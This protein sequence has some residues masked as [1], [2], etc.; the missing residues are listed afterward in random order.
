[1]PCLRAMA[2]A[3]AP[4]FVLG[5]AEQ[6]VAR[7][8]TSSEY[9]VPRAHRAQ[10]SARSLAKR[11]INQGQ[12]ALH[13]DVAEDRIARAD[14][15]APC[16]RAGFDQT[17]NAF[18]EI[19]WF[20]VR[21]HVHI[22]AAEG[23]DAIAVPGLELRCWEDRILEGVLAVNA[24]VLDEIRH[25]RLDVPTGVQKVRHTSPVGQLSEATVSWQ[26]VRT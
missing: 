26:D 11:L 23:G 18:S 3:G 21:E 7:P 2:G 20:G 13:R 10:G 12:V 14:G 5:G 16:R 17:P 1:M 4:G 25:D 6:A 15:E 24:D 8:D 19:L 9:G 22:D